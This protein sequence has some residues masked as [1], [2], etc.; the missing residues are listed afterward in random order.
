[1]NPRK[2]AF[3][4][5]HS[6]TETEEFSEPNIILGSHLAPGITGIEHTRRFD[7]QDLTFLF[8]HGFVLDTSWHHVHFTGG[9]LN[10]SV[11]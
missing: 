1:M 6:Q 10:A 11:P 7:Q 9:Q 3:T 4:C 8:G 5:G 2:R